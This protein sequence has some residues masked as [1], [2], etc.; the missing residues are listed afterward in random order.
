MTGLLG[1]RYRYVAGGCALAF[2]ALAYVGTGNPENK[3][4]QVDPSEYYCQIVAPY[5]YLSRAFIRETEGGKAR[6]RFDPSGNMDHRIANY[7]NKGSEIVGT[8]VDVRKNQPEGTFHATRE[9]CTLTDH[10]QGNVRVY[11]VK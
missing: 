2:G 9:K 10:Q 8:A 4:E 11:A 1:I 3:P 6:Y 7:V 5:G